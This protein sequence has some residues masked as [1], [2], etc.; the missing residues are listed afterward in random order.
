MFFRKKE[1]SGEIAKNRLQLVIQQDRMNTNPE[2][3]ASLKHE[4]MQVIKNYIEIDESELDLRVSPPAG[5]DEYT[6]ELN[7]P[8]KGW[9]RG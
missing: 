7:I 8:I 9:K 4:L 2:M 6:M 1:K 5:T 3:V